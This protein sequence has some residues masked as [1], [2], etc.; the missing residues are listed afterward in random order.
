MG[1][2][3]GL[4]LGTGL[5]LVGWS[6]LAP[7]SGWAAPSSPLRRPLRQLTAEAGLQPLRPVALVLGCLACSATTFVVAVGVGRS[8]VVATAFAA[9]ASWL[10]IALLRSRRDR[11]LGSRATAWP[12][13]LDD[14]GSAVRAGLALPEA[15]LQVGRRVPPQLAGAWAAF[16][17]EYRATARFDRALDVLKSGLADPVG[18]RVVEAL[19]VARDVGGNDLGGVLRTLSAFVRDD[20]RARSELAARQSWTVN[21]ARV[22]VGAPWVVLALL[23]L[24]PAAVAAYDSTAGAL[25]LGLG[26]L[27]CVVAYRVMRWI[28][29]L[30]REPRVLA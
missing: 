4:L 20:V 11:R 15:L 8:P 13:V 18:D 27:A 22:A 30:P 12:D 10:P 28:G 24:R 3:L 21:G 29:R 17:S 14:L 19:R 2:L 25:V 7:A 1:A 23:A 9:M 5:L 16:E 26:L 6:V